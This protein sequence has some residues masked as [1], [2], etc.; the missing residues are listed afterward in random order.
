MAELSVQQIDK[1]GLQASYASAESGGD[2]YPNDSER[3]FLH[4]KNGDSAEHTVTI[5]A[6]VS[7]TERPGFGTLSVSDISVAI[8]A[9]EDRFIGPVPRTAYG[10]K[11]DIQY[12]DV[13]SVSIAA[14][15]V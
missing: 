15:E 5:A 2:T 14:M 6:L 12:D 3:I 9:G 13:T 4:V 1:G 7:E 11:P 8:P 10:R